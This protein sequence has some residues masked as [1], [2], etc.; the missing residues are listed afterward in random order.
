MPKYQMQAPDGKTYEIEANDLN[1]AIEALSG[2]A[3]VT[4]GSSLG[5]P[6]PAPPG[7]IIHG[8]DGTS[9][10]ADQPNVKVERP[11]SGI[12]TPDA[13]RQ[14]AVAMEALKWRGNGGMGAARGLMPLGQGSGLGAMDE[15]VSG[16][17][18]ATAAARGGSFTD[19]YDLAQ[20]KQ[21]QELSAER[22]ENPWRSA[23]GEVAG[24]VVSTLP[25]AAA[26]ASR[27]IS[28]T[29]SGL[30]GLLARSAAGLVDGAALGAVSGAAGADAG[31]RTDGAMMGGAIGGVAGAAAPA[32]ASTLRAG[33]N[34]FGFTSAASRAN[35]RL[36]YLL[37][38]A[39]MSPDDIDQALA[40]ARADNQPEYMVGDAMGRTGRE[41]LAR[42]TR[43]ASDTGDEVYR[44]LETRAL[45][46]QRRLGGQI[47]EAATGQRGYTSG[48][49]ERD[50]LAARNAAA[51]ID[52]GAARAAAGAV[53][54]TAAIQRAD[55]FLNPGGLPMP[56]A[57]SPLPDDSVEAAVRRA[58]AM[59]TD[60]T[61]MLTDFDA[62]LRTKIE[63][64]TMIETAPGSKQRVLKPIRDALNDALSQAS[65]PYN[66]AR[67]GYR[68]ASQRAEAVTT[69]RDLASRG[70]FE[71]TLGTYGALSP[72]EQ[73]AARIGYGS[74][75]VEDVRAPAP[76]GD[77]TQRLRGVDT[78]QEVGAILGDR[79]NRQIS[80]EYDM[81][82]TWNR[83]AGN[84][85]TA[86]NMA[87]D[88]AGGS[89]LA[90]AIG[91]AAGLNVGGLAKR[92]LGWVL[93]QA[94]GER[95]PVRE[96]IAQALLTGQTGNLT[97][98]LAQ[99]GASM[100][101]IDTVTRALLA[102]TATQAADAP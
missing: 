81:F 62:V 1:A 3:A 86:Q 16:L 90:G 94:R 27:F 67:A 78:Q 8:G 60:G 40:A 19:A 74:K 43:T 29:A 97:Q 6:P 102:G 13:E 83:A 34:A 92:G 51:N 59:L 47:D 42:L 14:N 39:G 85:A 5:A 58:R 36:A 89:G 50:I 10:M 45:G 33:A 41:E 96:L 55:D 84:S 87:E 77:P 11:A 95:E 37:Q 76:T 100:R 7:A 64:D 75:L 80:R 48:M 98:Q 26:G 82:R 69:G 66:T 31:Q 24:S 18:G 91:D 44:T 28:P 79:T 35:E 88:A 21:R 63:L 68:A 9:Y 49:A 65:A 38:R 12:A 4:P 46:A 73:A 15:V 61:S 22:Q 70:R 30:R 57:Q 52:Y 71:D 53:D 93:A 101:I 56:A 2:F 20:E 72:E 25:L 23:A 54:P 32:I 99:R 17:T